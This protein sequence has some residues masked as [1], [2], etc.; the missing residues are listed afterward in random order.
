MR[1]IFI[2]RIGSSEQSIKVHNF[3]KKN[4]FVASSLQISITL[5]PRPHFLSP[6]FSSCGLKRRL[7]INKKRKQEHLLSGHQ[8][9]SPFSFSSDGTGLSLNVHP[10]V[11][12]SWNT[13]PKFLETY[14]ME[15]LLWHLSGG[16]T[17]KS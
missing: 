17:L 10:F 6:N 8:F 2:F 7:D 11:L 12:S 15:T 4:H 5:N 1:V 14:P 16:V 13:T 3:R 9:I